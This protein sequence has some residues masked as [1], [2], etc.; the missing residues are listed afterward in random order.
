MNA[1]NRAKLIRR[2]YQIGPTGVMYVVIAGLLI[3]VAI[4]TQANL[5]FW[6]FGVVVGGLIVSVITPWLMMRHLSVRRMLP[7]HAVAG[8]ETRLRYRVENRKHVVPV[9][10]LVIEERWN[11]RRR[12]RTTDPH[13]IEDSPARLL[14]R[15]HGWAMHLGPNQV[16]HVESPCWPLRRGRLKFDRIAVSTSFPFGVIKRTAFY[17]APGQLLIYPHLYRLNRRLIYR[18]SQTDPSG[19]KQVDRGGGQEEFFGLRQYRP[20]DSLKLIDWRKTARTGELVSRELTK[21]SPPR[22]LIGLDLIGYDADQAAGKSL[23]KSRRQSASESANQPVERAV[24]LAAS[25]VCEAY[26]NGY[27]VGLVV[28]GAHCEPFP[29][30]HSLP[31][32][33]RILE[34]LATLELASDAE[35][36]WPGEPS[37]VIHLGEHGDARPAGR[38]ARHAAVVDATRM[39]EYVRELSEGSADVLGRYEVQTSRRAELANQSPTSMQEVG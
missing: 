5:L 16:T 1:P 32:R 27:Q 9:F 3:A 39:D 33:M 37:V 22:V 11:K 18:L 23:F 8:E 14:G 2:R 10:G 24:S 26:L 12:M 28:A 19:R 21:P 30:H 13:P 4:Y 35:A 6:A 25:L 17:E 34:A 15:P 20:G 31:H 7:D 36:G 38:V 29:L